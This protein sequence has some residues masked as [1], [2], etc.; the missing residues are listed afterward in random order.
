MN[1]DLL[2]RPF[3][4][5]DAGE[6]KRLIREDILAI[7]SRDYGLETAQ[8]LA[9]AYTDD[10]INLYTQKAV[11]FIIVKEG[12]IVGTAGLQDGRVRNVFTHK[13]CQ[14]QGIGRRLMSAVEDEARRQGLNRLKLR[15]NLSAAGFYAHL[16]YQV[17]E[18]K[19]ETIGQAV[20][21][22]IWM[23]KDL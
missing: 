21:K 12:C 20:M 17:V 8:Q 10:L 14:R 22:M 3:Q 1:D 19:E 7:N 23:Q 9:D 5:N 4:N 15:A 16:G 13:A 6:L 18:E 2:I 11:V